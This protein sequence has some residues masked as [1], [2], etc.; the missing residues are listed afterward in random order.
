M[1]RGGHW[2]VPLSRWKY[3]LRE[4]NYLLGLGTFT[5]IK[6]MINTGEARTG[7]KKTRRT[8]YKCVGKE[9]DLKKMLWAVV[10]RSSTS[11]LT[12][13]PVLLRKRDRS[14]RYYIDYRALNA[15]TV[16][17]L[18]PLFLIALILYQ[19]IIGFPS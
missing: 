14:V 4:G 3:S 1:E 16:K 15:V 11:E 7:K 6:H 13:V 18:Y 8:P 17:D 10:I 19:K 12:F 2:R 5:D 9:K